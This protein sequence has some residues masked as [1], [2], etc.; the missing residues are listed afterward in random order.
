MEWRECCVT[1][2]GMIGK[3]HSYWRIRLSHLILPSDYS[4]GSASSCFCDPRLSQADPAPLIA[5]R[6][7]PEGPAPGLNDQ[8]KARLTKPLATPALRGRPPFS[9]LVHGR[10]AYWGVAVQSDVRRMPSGVWPAE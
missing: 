4:L 2:L 8:P 5:V 3:P 9:G 6:P 1:A 7:G 10:V